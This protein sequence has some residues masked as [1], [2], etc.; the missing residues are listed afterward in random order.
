MLRSDEQASRMVP[1]IVEVMTAVGV[2][3]REIDG[4]VVGAGPGSF[5]GL[6]IAAACAKGLAYTLG[7]PLWA[8][9]SLAAGAV[10]D[11]VMPWGA[12][13]EGWWADPTAAGSDRRYV[14]FDARGER[15]Y[16]ACY[17]VTGQTVQ[18]RIPGYP[19]TV[20]ELLAAPGLEG[21]GFAGDAAERHR[22][23]FLAAGRVVLGAPAGTPT[24]DALIALLAQSPDRTP[25][26]DVPRWEPQYLKASSAERERSAASL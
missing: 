3:R 12:G 26:A 11:L 17:D 7:L 10:S 24:A 25:V 18:E 22:H 21:V 1:S 4:V 14:L 2:S 16:A 19:T 8:I 23:R 20:T 6:R 13:P 15:V 9:S 5:T